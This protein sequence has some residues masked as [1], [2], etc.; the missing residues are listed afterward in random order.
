MLDI[1]QLM[2]FPVKNYRNI[3]RNSLF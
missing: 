1:N 2:D 3:N